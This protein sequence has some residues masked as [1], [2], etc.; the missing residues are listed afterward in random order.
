MYRNN[1]LE[2]GWQKI[3]SNV[4]KFNASTSNNS[5]AYIDKN[6]DVWILGD[7]SNFLGIESENVYAI[8]NFIN[9]IRLLSKYFS[10]NDLL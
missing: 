6:N 1:I 7:R 4:K 9:L 10:I 3:A 8:N 5:L 2:G